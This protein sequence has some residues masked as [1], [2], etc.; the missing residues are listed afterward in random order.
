M[1]FC[2]N[3]KGDIMNFLN[4]YDI[5][6]DNKELLLTALTHS[7]YA[8]EH[9]C[10]SYE[11]LE[12]LGDAV[13]QLIISEYLYN[14]M[15]K[16]EGEMSKIRASYVCEEALYAYSK[17]VNYLPFVRVGH[18]QITNI[19]ETIIADMFESVLG[20]IYL[21]QGFNVAKAYI[22]KV[23]VPYIKKQTIFLSDYKSALQEM[24]QMN[25]KTLT[26]ELV[27]ESGP[28]NDRNFEVVVKIDKI[29]FGR[30]IGK[31]KKDAEQ[32]A[33]KDAFRHQAK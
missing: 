10:S 24:T 30:G 16:D 27:K 11:R 8:N 33:A 18:G 9:N 3:C 15:F 19:N 28:A 22:Y 7:S 6:I 32:Q 12:Y 26:Y 17:D 25:R 31:S 29:I 20:A 5:N 21:D 2:Y 23:V 13:L 4:K 1:K 14:N